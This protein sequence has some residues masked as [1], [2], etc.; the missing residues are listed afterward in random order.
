MISRGLDI[1]GTVRSSSCTHVG[2]TKDGSTHGVVFG[3]AERDEKG[4]MVL[5]GSLFVFAAP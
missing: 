2:P 5:A 4:D 3:K 1:A